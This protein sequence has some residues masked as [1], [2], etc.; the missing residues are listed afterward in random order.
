M[1]PMF[2]IWGVN[3]FP[4]NI[5]AIINVTDYIQQFNK[6]ELNIASY[7]LDSI[8]CFLLTKIVPNKATVDASLSNTWCFVTE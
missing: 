6:Q 7:N 5:S 3:F 8:F 1:T 4:L 2:N